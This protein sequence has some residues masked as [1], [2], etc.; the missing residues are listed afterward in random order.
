MHHT[1]IDHGILRK[2]AAAAGQAA[3]NIGNTLGAYLG[4]VP[5]TLG[6]AYNYPS[7]VGVGMA[8]T[9]A[10]LAYV[11]LVKVVRAQMNV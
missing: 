2:P 6:L 5:I 11:F 10:V 9:G 4:A 8:A 1:L 7:L 3:F